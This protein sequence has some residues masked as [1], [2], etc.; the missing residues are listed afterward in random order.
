MLKVILYG[1][2]YAFLFFSRGF[3]ISGFPLISLTSLIHLELIFVQ[4]ARYESV[5]FFSMWIPSFPSLSFADNAVCSPVCVCS[6]LNRLSYSLCLCVLCSCRA[7]FI[8]LRGMLLPAHGM[9]WA[10]CFLLLPQHMFWHLCQIS[11]DCNYVYSCLDLQFCYV[12]Q[13]VCF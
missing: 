13:S 5:S 7:L 8:P 9:P 12:G 1:S 11:D 6:L 3:N 10:R 4:G 2:A